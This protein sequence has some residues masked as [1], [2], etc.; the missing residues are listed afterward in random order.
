MELDCCWI[1]DLS[2]SEMETDRS[3]HQVLA[4][5]L[6]RNR[7]LVQGILQMI[8][9]DGAVDGEQRLLTRKNNSKC[10]KMS[11]QSWIDCEA[12]SSW[13]HAGNVLGVVDVLQSQ[14]VPTVPVTVINMLPDDGVRSCCPI[15]INFRHVHVI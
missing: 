1:E 5:L 10:C 15:N 11:L 7:K 12:S 13:I 2:T 8:R 3:S 9:H 6:D 4:V 14:F